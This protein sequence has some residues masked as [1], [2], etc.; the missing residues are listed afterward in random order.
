[1]IYR[2]RDTIYGLKPYDIFAMGK[3]DE[4]VKVHLCLYPFFFG[5]IYPFSI[6]FYEVPCYNRHE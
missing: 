1:M 3:Y 2:L 4:R 5:V 6:A